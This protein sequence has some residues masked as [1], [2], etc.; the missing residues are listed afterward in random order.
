MLISWER[1]KAR[2]EEAEPLIKG[3]P[4]PTEAMG[5]GQGPWAGES[6]EEYRGGLEKA[7]EA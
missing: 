5:L 1:K 7:A 3:F 6:F 4:R 2:R